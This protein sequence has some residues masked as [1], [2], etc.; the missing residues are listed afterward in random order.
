MKIGVKGTDIFTQ[1]KTSMAD[2]R[3]KTL[4]AMFNSPKEVFI[5]IEIIAEEAKLLEADGLIV[6]ESAKL[7]L[8]VADM[9]FVETR[10]ARAADE[11]EKGL[12]TRFKDQLDKESLLC[13]VALNE[14]EKTLAAGYSMLSLRPVFVA[15]PQDLEDK[16]KL[17]LAAYAHAGYISFFTAGDKDAHAWSIKKGTTAYDAAGVIHTAI[18]QGFIRAE[19]VNFKELVADGGLSKARSNNHVRLEMKE[20]VVQDGDYLVIRTNK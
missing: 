17:L 13:D 12:L 19:V 18:Q 15:K 9:E 6:T 20:Y 4:K 10:L 1:G 8:V 5:Q 16:N 2:E 3:V 11:A 14:Q 7:D